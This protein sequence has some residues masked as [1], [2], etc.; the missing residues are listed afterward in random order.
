M[1]FQLYRMF[2]KTLWR[3]I[4]GYGQSFWK[5]LDFFK[6]QTKRIHNFC[7][8]ILNLVL[9]HATQARVLLQSDEHMTI[10]GSP[11]GGKYRV[12]H[13]WCLISKINLNAFKNILRVKLYSELCDQLS[14]DDNGGKYH[15]LNKF[16]KFRN[17]TLVKMNPLFCS[18][19]LTPAFS[20]YQVPV[21]ILLKRRVY[22]TGF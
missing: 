9:K 4:S 20:T 2:N 7:S 10:P 22:T 5:E 11:W 6:V 8:Q 14:P 21:E 17:E 15:S 18:N 19:N 13:V 1:D 3:E 16:Q 12:D